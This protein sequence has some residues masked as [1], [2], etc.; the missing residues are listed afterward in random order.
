MGWSGG[1]S[2]FAELIYILKKNV[3]DDEV[4]REIYEHMVD[5]FM[6]QD[7]DTLDE[8]TGEDDEY[9]AVYNSLYPKDEGEEEDYEE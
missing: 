7:W 2:L 1:S 4:R 8:C 6:D 3:P 5:A 9:D